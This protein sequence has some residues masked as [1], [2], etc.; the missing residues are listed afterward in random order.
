M[1]RLNLKPTHKHLQVSRVLFWLRAKSELITRL[2]RIPLDDGTF[3]LTSGSRGSVVAHK[4][5]IS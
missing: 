1:R 4:G 3:V 2:L 5:N